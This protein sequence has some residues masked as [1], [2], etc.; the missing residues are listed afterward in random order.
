MHSGEMNRV[1]PA[2]CAIIKELQM[3]REGCEVC[4]NVTTKNVRLLESL[5]HDLDM[6]QQL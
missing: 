6:F 5:R 4:Q 1:F 2:E 3:R